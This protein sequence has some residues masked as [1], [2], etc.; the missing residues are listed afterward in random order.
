MTPNRP[1][2]PRPEET[3]CVIEQMRVARTQPLG[4]TYVG[5]GRTTF[6]VWAPRAR[7]IAV[8]LV[9]QHDRT[10]ELLPTANHYFE[11]TI[12][13]V[14]LGD[15]YLF[16]IDGERALPDPASRSQPDGVHGPSEVVSADFDW[17]DQGWFGLPWAEYV[18]YE[19]HVGTFTDE[20]TFDA[21]IP[22]LDGL[23]QL[24]VTAIELMPVA[25]NP[26]QRNWGYDGA[27]PFAVQRS[28]GGSAGL[29]RLVDACHARELAVV[30]DVVYNHLGP[31]GNYLAAF[32]PYFTEHYHSPWGDAINFDGPHSDQVRRYFLENA[33]RWVHEFHID[34]LRLDA[35][36]HIYDFSAYPFLTELGDVLRAS[37]LETEGWQK[38]RRVFLIA[39]T[40]QNDPRVLRSGREGGL[41]LDAHWHDE[42]H[43]GL[44]VLLTGEQAS[45]YVDFG[46]MRDLADAYTNGYVY[47]GHYSPFFQRRHGQAL[48]EVDRSRLVV[49]GQNHDQVGNRAKSDR[50]GT[51]L[52]LEGQK[53]VAAAVILSPFTP[54]LFMGEEFGET[55]P[56]WYFV[57]HGDP[58]LVRAV[59]RGRRLEYAGLLDD[60][61]IAD[62]ASEETFRQCRIDHSRKQ[63]EPGRTLFSYYQH[64]LRLRPVLPGLRDRPGVTTEA[65]ASE[66]GR[67]LIVT[68]REVDGATTA[69][70]MHFGSAP[71]SLELA[72]PAGRWTRALDSADPRWLG[73]GSDLPSLLESTGSVRLTLP[74]R[75]LAVFTR[76]PE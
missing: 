7:Q 52:C 19:L 12:D 10:V 76:D 18:F 13:G 59:Q 26:G 40:N 14:G 39:E 16:V 33:L 44:H 38:P 22:H 23:K 69:L 74:G 24:G 49:F 51:M 63:R 35:T 27:Y 61:D 4:A 58:E 50:Y 72:L 31:E 37:A 54:L 6:R 29:K 56:F 21:V 66:E 17:H 1:N 55:A 71:A 28:Y 57:D 8:R 48:G 32:G 46:R 2:D 3:R 75:S 11:N 53:L 70:L 20:G 43:H 30:L 42:F 45:Y 41:G 47:T 64:L 60:G 62:P 67:T 34:A 25:Q 5:D 9:S 15:R 65:I 73:P 68:R 36:S